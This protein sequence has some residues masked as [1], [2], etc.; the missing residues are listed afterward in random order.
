[1]AAATLPSITLNASAPAPANGSP[2][3]PFAANDGKQSFQQVLQAR[4]AS[5][6]SESKPAQP[7]AGAVRP[8]QPAPAQGAQAPAE[9][10][11]EPGEAGSEALTTRVAQSLLKD[12]KLLGEHGDDKALDEAATALTA[13]PSL[14]PPLDPNAAA[15]LA[16]T[17]NLAGKPA[18]DAATPEGATGPDEN[19]G[20]QPREARET[21]GVADALKTE[22]SAGALR[23]DAA[24]KA[25]PLEGETSFANALASAQQNSAPHA[26]SQVNAAGMNFM[27]N[28]AELPRHEVN[29][30]VATRGWA[31]EVSQKL[32]WIATRDAGR[33]EL[34]LNPPQLGR[35]EVSINVQGDQASAAFVAANPITREA[36][37]DAMPRLREVLAQA[38]IQLGQASVDVGTGSQPQTQ[39]EAHAGSRVFGADARYGQAESQD[40]LPLSLAGARAAPSS[41]RGMIDTFA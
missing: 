30:P 25:G 6:A 37:Q 23:G 29:T 10:T 9:A 19:L 35:I 33:A 27:Q 32:N 7:Q 15:A 11:A 21:R 1:M 38:G 14:A 3:T 2:A 12:G 26:Q 28:R 4:A 20:A 17:A 40:A 18:R 41:G 24:Q 39:Q 16:A 34:V 13:E 31:D 8:S 22:A 5:K 36:L